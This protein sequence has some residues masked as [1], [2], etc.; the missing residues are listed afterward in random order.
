MNGCAFGTFKDTN[1][2]CPSTL[3][4]FN[5]QL[6]LFV[7]GEDASLAYTGENRHASDTRFGLMDSIVPIEALLG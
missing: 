2:G 5:P 7:L 6:G 4:Y 1:K 3:Y